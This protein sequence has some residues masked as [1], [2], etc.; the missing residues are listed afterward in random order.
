MGGKLLR[1]RL[2]KRKVFAET[3]AGW[4]LNPASVKTSLFAHS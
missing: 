4:V 2:N 1:S 3:N